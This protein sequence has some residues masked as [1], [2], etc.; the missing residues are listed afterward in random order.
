M[1]LDSLRG[2]AAVLVVLLHMGGTG[3]ILSTAFVRNGWL[4][5]DFFFVLSGF[6]LASAYARPLAGTFSLSRFMI[7]RLGRI[8]P[9]HAAVL[10]VLLA[11]ELA[12]A[13]GAAAIGVDRQAFTYPQQSWEW[14]W[15]TALLIQAWFPDA[16]SAWNAQS[17]SISVELWL[18]VGLALVMRLAGMRGLY[19]IVGA[20]LAAI[21]VLIS[22]FDEFVEPLSWEMLH[23]IAGFG[24]GVGAWRMHERLRQPLGKL[25]G[26]WL[27]LAEI[28]TSTAAIAFV[29]SY[30]RAVDYLPVLLVFAALVL[31]FAQ[32]RGLVSR[33]LARRPFV[34]LG[35]LSYSLYMVHFPIIRRRDAFARFLGFDTVPAEVAQQPDVIVAAPW[36]VD[37]FGFAMLGLALL[38][39]HVCWRV[40]E[41]PARRWSRRKAEKWGQ[42]GPEGLAP[43]F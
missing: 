8:Y 41:D 14:F 31:V 10:L 33:L 3:P 38:A 18:Y 9:V 22:G 16:P 23:G 30:A 32:D 19:W 12:L 29:S 15:K 35:I 20:G 34:A 26:H 43:T 1:A 11:Y 6:V 7:L 39:A 24:I 25:E 40:V 36:V 27:S 21:A 4:A 28:I 42:A 17:W 13:T 5:V 37:L 2:L